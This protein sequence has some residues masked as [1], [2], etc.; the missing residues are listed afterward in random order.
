MEAVVWQLPSES[1]ALIS[2]MRALAT[3][4]ACKAAGHSRPAVGQHCFK[5]HE[6]FI[7]PTQRLQQAAKIVMRLRKVGLELQRALILIYCISASLAL[8]CHGEIVSLVRW[9]LVRQNDK[10]IARRRQDKRSKQ[11]LK[12]SHRALLQPPATTR[13]SRTH[14]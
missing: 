8:D 10:L 11:Q 13:N 9:H 12:Q 5:V 4:S 14:L 3:A 2:V 7:R 1:F 6:R